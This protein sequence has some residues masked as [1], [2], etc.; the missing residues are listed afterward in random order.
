M[1]IVVQAPVNMNH[2]QQPTHTPKM[3][4]LVYSLYH[5]VLLK[6]S[7]E[8]IKANMVEGSGRFYSI[9]YHVPYYCK[10]PPCHALYQYM[11]MYVCTCEDSL[12]TS[13]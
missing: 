5:E 11:Y 3:E 4:T 6:P 13:V 2:H 1:Y 8:L 12:C 7:M 10:L 9:L